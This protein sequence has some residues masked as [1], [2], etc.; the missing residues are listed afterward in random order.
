MSGKACN[1]FLRKEGFTLIE[2][3]VVIAI[4]AILAAI[5]F[6]VFAKAREK[7]R[8]TQ[9]TN[10]QKQ[11]TTAVLMYVQEHDEKLPPAQSFWSDIDVPAKVKQCP[12]A[13]KNIPN[14]YV[15]NKLLD[16]LAIGEIEYPHDTML[17]ADGQHT[18]TGAN[19][20]DNMA[21]AVADFA[22][23]HNNLCIVGYLDGHVATTKTP[24]PWIEVCVDHLVDPNMTHP[25]TIAATAGTSNTVHFGSNSTSTTVTYSFP[26]GWSDKGITFAPNLNF[27]VPIHELSVECCAVETTAAT[28]MNVKVNFWDKN[29]TLFFGVLNTDDA[30]G[31]SGNVR[32]TGWHRCFLNFDRT[33]VKGTGY[34]QY[35]YPLDPSDRTRTVTQPIPNF[36]QI[37]LSCGGPATGTF[38]MNDFVV[39]AEA[40]ASGLLK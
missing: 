22:R 38:Y 23:R 27:A 21:S 37:L 9:C 6:P 1:V 14:A 7:A 13:G 11:I 29:G 15:A 31:G 30:T 36:N 24:D 35:Y 32:N 10:N 12:T 34:G 26:S 5:L 33:D 2:L 4:I 18:N 20:P 8:Q 40:P 39:K 17:V 19:D 16:N 25:Y 28:G 3:L